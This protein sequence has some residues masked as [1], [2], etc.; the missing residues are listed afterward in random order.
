[1]IIVTVEV[2][3]EEGSIEKVKDALGVM[4]TAS[5]EEAGC[6]TYAFS[7]DLNDPGMVRV[8]EKWKS[9]EDLEAHFK[10]PHMATFQEAVGALAPKSIE[11][12]AYEVA[13]EVTLPF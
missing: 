9:M 8:T 7:V 11:V 3:V 1:M 13:G 5:R 10:M 6:I 12:K 2:G 4:E